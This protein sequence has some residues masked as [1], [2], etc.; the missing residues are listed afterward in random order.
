MGEEVKE[1]HGNRDVSRDNDD[2]DDHEDHVIELPHKPPRHHK[3]KENSNETVPEL[4]TIPDDD[5]II[6][7]D[8]TNKSDD[9]TNHSYDDIIKEGKQY[10][11]L[12]RGTSNEIP[13]TEE[14]E[15]NHVE[16]ELE[17]EEKQEEKLE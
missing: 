4:S 2:N 9:I 16:T 11:M 1:I 3:K 15:L 10:L 12:E 13:Q 14:Q 5:I 8:V 6:V 7:D 17:Q